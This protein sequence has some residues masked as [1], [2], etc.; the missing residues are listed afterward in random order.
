MNWAPSR[1]LIFNCA[2][3]ASGIS[4]C[5]QLPDSE[6]TFR[7]LKGADGGLGRGVRTDLDRVGSRQDLGRES[8]LQFDLDRYALRIGARAIS[9]LYAA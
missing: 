8:S 2:G 3:K 6:K 7:L 1:W 9:H 5:T 4:I